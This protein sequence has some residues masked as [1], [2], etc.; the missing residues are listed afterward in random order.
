[1]R[2]A[3]TSE[4]RD[5]RIAISE[6]GQ[7]RPGRASSKS[8]NVRYAES[9]SKFKVL[10]TQRR[11]LRVDG[12]ARDMIQALKPEPPIMRYELSDEEW[13]TITP[14]LPNKPRGVR[15]VND[16]RVLNGVFWS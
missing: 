13:S 12:D 4:R 9:G 6:L 8:G 7:A 5:K 16:R 1:M 11:A 3:R 2:S 10:A 15:R 14:M